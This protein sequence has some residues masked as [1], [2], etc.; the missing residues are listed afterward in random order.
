MKKTY[1]FLAVLVAINTSLLSQTAWIEQQTSY[2]LNQSISCLYFFNS[3]EGI[4][5]GGSGVF[6]RTTNGGINWIQFSTNSNNHYSSISFI[7]NYTGWVSGGFYNYTNTIEMLRKTTDGGLTWDSLYFEPTGRMNDI[8]FLDNNT[9]FMAGFYLKKTTNGGLNWF[10]I[11]DYMSIFGNYHIFFLNSMTG[12]AAKLY[13]APQ[14]N[15]FINKLVKTTNGG[16]N[17]ITQICDSNT[18]N[19]SIEGIH[20]I[21]ENT[22]FIGLVHFGIKKTTDGGQSWISVFNSQS[23]YDIKFINDN[24]GWAGSYADILMTTNC[25][26]NWSKGFVSQNCTFNTI[27][28]INE[29]TGW[30][31]GGTGTFPKLF[32]TTTGGSVYV[33][34]ISSGI[35]EKYSLFQNYP[36][37]FNPETRIRY[38]LP[39]S[40]FVSLVVYDALGREIEALVDESQ[41]AGTYEAVF[42]ASAIP[43]GVYFYR[44]TAGEFSETRKMV[45]IK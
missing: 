38:S 28:F 17:W 2:G 11:D 42:N 6:A 26:I 34:N 45:L 14:A 19:N 25:G 1:F 16:Q 5:C 36:N 7:N 22:G 32:K 3:Q 13:A 8:Q 37:P 10:V 33:N 4:I 31:A 12:W 20:F 43:S 18:I 24:T 9:G 21:N 44:L 15:T 29:L 41:R 39:R 30:A 35:P 23:C 40:S 27:N